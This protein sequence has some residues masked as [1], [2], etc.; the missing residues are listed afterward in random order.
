MLLV[1]LRR[2]PSVGLVLVE[3][4]RHIAHERQAARSAFGRTQAEHARRSHVVGRC[5]EINDE[6]LREE[7]GPLIG[8]GASTMNEDVGKRGRGI[9]DVG[10]LREGMQDL[11]DEAV[12]GL[13]LM[14]VV[15]RAIG[16]EELFSGVDRSMVG[17]VVDDQ[18]RQ[19]GHETPAGGVVGGVGNVSPDPF[20]EPSQDGLVLL[21]YE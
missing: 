11:A 8:G 3:V 4:V 7:V 14:L 2:H 16:V 6:R 10:R 13:R 9:A 21:D 5:G 20:E 12:D 18:Q 17:F 19:I 15:G 1:V